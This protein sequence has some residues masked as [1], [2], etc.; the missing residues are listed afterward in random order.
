MKD[1]IAVV[2]VLVAILEQV[3]TFSLF[4]KGWHDYLDSLLAQSTPDIYSALS[5][6]FP[7]HQWGKMKIS[8]YH[9]LGVALGVLVFFML[10]K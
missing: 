10:H 1:W 7:D 8:I 2:A 4:F 5:G 6:N 9:G 3:L